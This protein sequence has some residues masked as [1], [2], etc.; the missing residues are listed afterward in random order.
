MCLQSRLPCIFCLW[1][2]RMVYDYCLVDNK[3]RFRFKS[4]EQTSTRILRWSRLIVVEKSVWGWKKGSKTI[5]LLESLSL[6]T[7]LNWNRQN[8]QRAL[9]CGIF[10]TKHKHWTQLCKKK[11]LQWTRQLS[12]VIQEKPAEIRSAK[13]TSFILH[14]LTKELIAN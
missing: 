14:H 10:R 2:V 4:F 5:L 7:A 13:L 3:R 12:K 6:T 11:I 1:S 9:V 8:C